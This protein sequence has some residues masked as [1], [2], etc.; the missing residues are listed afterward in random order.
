MADKEEKKKLKAQI[1]SV[2]DSVEAMKIARKSMA[3]FV[4]SYETELNHNEQK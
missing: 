3:K 2:E 4:S 1:K